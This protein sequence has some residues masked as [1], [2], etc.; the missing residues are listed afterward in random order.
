MAQWE[1]SGR[2]IHPLSGW[3]RKGA[4]YT[5]HMAFNLA[6]QH[7]WVMTDRRGGV[8]W[9]SWECIRSLIK[10]LHSPHEQV[11]KDALTFRLNSTCA[12]LD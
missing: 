10:R 12:S 9:K 6:L 4:L 11:A 3:L 8:R 7:G 1:R 5:R 2:G